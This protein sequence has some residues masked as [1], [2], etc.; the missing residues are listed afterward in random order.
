MLILTLDMFPILFCNAHWW[1]LSD[2]RLFRP[3]L[4]QVLEI[5]VFRHLDK[6]WL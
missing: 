2:D 5:L 1:V 6:T 3:H 4:H